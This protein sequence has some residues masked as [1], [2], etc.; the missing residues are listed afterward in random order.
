M[1]EHLTREQISCKVS[2][3]LQQLQPV[4]HKQELTFL[5]YNS[6]ENVSEINDVTQILHIFSQINFIFFFLPV[7]HSRI[8]CNNFKEQH[9]K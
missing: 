2:D 7:N 8:K 1:Q 4:G 9:T 5:S 6:A 3:I